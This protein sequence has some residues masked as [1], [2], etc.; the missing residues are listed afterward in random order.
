MVVM[1]VALEEPDHWPVQ[2]HRDADADAGDAIELRD[3]DARTGPES[4]RRK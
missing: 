2:A 4:N 3:V 1:S